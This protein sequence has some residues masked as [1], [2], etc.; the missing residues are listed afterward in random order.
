MRLFRNNSHLSENVSF[1]VFTFSLISCGSSSM[2]PFPLSLAKTVVLTSLSSQSDVWTS[3]GMVFVNL[4]CSFEWGVCVFYNKACGFVGA[5]A[6]AEG[7]SS[8]C[9]LRQ[10]TQRPFLIVGDR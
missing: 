9:G 6:I 4:C 2:F 7:R 3:S 10:F 8:P 1:G 5:V